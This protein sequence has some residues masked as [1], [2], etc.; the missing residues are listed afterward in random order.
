MAFVE[1]LFVS[2]AQAFRTSPAFVM[3]TLLPTDESEINHTDAQRF[4]SIL[5]GYLTWVSRH[6]NKERPLADT[7]FIPGARCAG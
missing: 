6:P 4:R 1:N 3:R 2:S 5:S 7:N